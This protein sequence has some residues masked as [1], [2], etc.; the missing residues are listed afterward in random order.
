MCVIRHANM[1]V[2]PYVDPHFG[3]GHHMQIYLHP[4][5]AL[6]IEYKWPVWDSPTVT[7]DSQMLISPRDSKKVKILKET[8]TN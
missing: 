7:V 4:F 3:L 6:S 8:D 1:D 5:E 2:T